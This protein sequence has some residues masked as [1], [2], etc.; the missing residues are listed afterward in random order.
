M[1]TTALI[2]A[3]LGLA[4]AVLLIYA[5]VDVRRDAREARLGV[6]YEWARYY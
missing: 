5:V 1:E 3:G 2:L 4:G 6:I